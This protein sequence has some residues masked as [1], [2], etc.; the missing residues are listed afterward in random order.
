M[1]HPALE[2]SAQGHGPVGAGPEEGHKN[3]PRAGAPLLQDRLRELG[4]FILEKRR[5]WGNLI[6][7]FQYLKGDY[8][9][10]GDRYFRGAC[11]NR[12]RVNGF[13]LKE[14]R[15]RLDIRKKIFTMGVV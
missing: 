10:D 14:Y 5:L 3:D 12:T 13:K 4:L 9:K 8:R 1:L 15:Y 11:C 2:P 7:A 6:V